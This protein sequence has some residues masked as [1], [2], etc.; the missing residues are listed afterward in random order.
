MP[1]ACTEPAPRHQLPNLAPCAAANLAPARSPRASH[2]AGSFMRCELDGWVRRCRLARNHQPGARC[3][4]PHCAPL[5]PTERRRHPPRVR[6]GHPPAAQAALRKP[7]G[8]R[9]PLGFHH[10]HAADRW[11]A[12]AEPST[13]LDRIR[14][15]DAGPHRHA[16]RDLAGRAG[17]HHRAGPVVVDVAHPDVGDRDDRHHGVVL[18]ARTPVP[19]RE[20]ATDAGQRLR[21]DLGR[22]R[23]VAH[24]VRAGLLR[25]TARRRVQPGLLRAEHHRSGALA[26]VGCRQLTGHRRTADGPTPVGRQG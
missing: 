17:E 3:P 15:G 8:V 22:E 25:G 14:G 5:P 4:T 16:E 26:R 18:P 12:G 7:P 1:Q 21:V 9:G 24:R 20:G 10:E 6:P 13:R 2:G 19:A 23:S 11:G